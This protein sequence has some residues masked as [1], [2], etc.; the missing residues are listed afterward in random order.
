MQSKLEHI[1]AVLIIPINTLDTC[2][3]LASQLRSNE[4]SCDISFDKKLGKAMDYANK[5]SIPFVAIV[6]EKEL[7]DNL[8]NIRDMESG[9]EELY[10]LSTV[11]IRLKE[12]LRQSEQTHH[13]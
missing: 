9:K 6:G 4:V 1:P 12:S 3:G 10:D 8:V 13:S 2:L 7:K 11:G 5:Q